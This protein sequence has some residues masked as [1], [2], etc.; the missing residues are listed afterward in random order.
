MRQTRIIIDINWLL[1]RPIHCR[2]QHK[3]RIS[4][5]HVCV[6]VCG[7]SRN[8][9]RGWWPLI[10]ISA[11]RRH[12]LW[13]QNVA[14]MAGRWWDQSQRLRGFQP[15]AG[16][17]C[18]TSP[19]VIGHGGF[20]IIVI[21]NLPQRT[22]NTFRITIYVNAAT[23]VNQPHSPALGWMSACTVRMVHV[24]LGACDSHNPVGSGSCSVIN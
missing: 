12:D 18:A 11:G 3:R 8:L 14:Y 5:V 24:D 13:Q 21:W 22:R 10:F 20:S 17:I 16:R 9:G 6:L 19:Q 4:C 2:P 1:I 15:G 23:N 7:H